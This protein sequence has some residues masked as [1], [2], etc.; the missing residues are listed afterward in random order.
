MGK[1]NIIYCLLACL[2]L[3]GGCIQKKQPLTTPNTKQTGK[4]SCK[5][6]SLCWATVTGLLSQIWLIRYKP[7]KVSPLYMQTSLIRKFWAQ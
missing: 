1:S 2:F 5:T 3:S 6:N 7:G 4:P